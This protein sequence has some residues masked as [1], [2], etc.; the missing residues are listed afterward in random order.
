MVLLFAATGAVTW[1]FARR[2]PASTLSYSPPSTGRTSLHRIQDEPSASDAGFPSIPS[3]TGRPTYLYS[4]IPGGIESVEELRQATAHD[5]VAAQHF[6][7]FD[8]QRAHLVRVSQEQ[9][10]Y[11]AYRIGQKVYWTRKKIS[12]HPGETLISDG[13]IVARTRCGNRVAL[14]PLGPHAMVD[15][16]EADFDQP[17]FSSDMVTRD[18]DPLMDPYLTYLPTPDLANVLQPTHQRK[19]LIPFFV[20]PFFGLPGATSHTPLA[21]TPEPGAL[22]LLSTGLAG[23][24]WWSRK[25]RRKR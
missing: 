8:Y 20:L 21:V 3:Q 15:P 16:L 10:M 4:L 14:A 25:S 18:V 24:Y 11:V 19:R 23:M 2:P 5:P 17:L 9:S 6:E 1:Q 12:L 13:K 22:L 7:G